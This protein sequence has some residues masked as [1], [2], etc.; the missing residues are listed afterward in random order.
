MLAR[1]VNCLSIN[2]ERAYRS[3]VEIHRHAPPVAGDECPENSRKQREGGEWP[4][5][6]QMLPNTSARHAWIG[7]DRWQRYGRC[8]G[9]VEQASRINTCKVSERC[10]ARHRRK[11]SL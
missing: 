10:F 5:R 9:R 2:G 7:L 6:M 4:G 3:H 1:S 11:L 8:R